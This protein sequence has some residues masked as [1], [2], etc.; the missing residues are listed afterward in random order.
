MIAPP[1]HTRQLAVAM[2]SAAT[3]PRHARG[4]YVEG[5]GNGECRAGR[6]LALHLGSIASGPDSDEPETQMRLSALPPSPPRL[7][8]PTPRPLPSLSP[9]W[10]DSMLTLGL[11][12]GSSFSVRR[13]DECAVVSPSERQQKPLSRRLAWPTPPPSEVRRVLRTVRLLIAVSPRGTG[14]AARETPQ[15]SRADAAAHPRLGFRLVLPFCFA[16]LHDFFTFGR[17][18]PPFA[19]A[20]SNSSGVR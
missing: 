11:P 16:Q 19:L 3:S 5:T 14:R 17:C 8:A 13:Q 10:P 20:A 9:P 7:I 6:L 15:R 12:F 1:N 2:V 18:S 4:P